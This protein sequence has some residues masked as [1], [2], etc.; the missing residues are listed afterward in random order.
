VPYNSGDNADEVMHVGPEWPAIAVV[1]RC[2]G[3]ASPVDKRQAR[4]FSGLLAGEEVAAAGNSTRLP[5]GPGVCASVPQPAPGPDDD[6][7]INRWVNAAGR[8]ACGP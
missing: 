4:H 1:P 8:G 2:P 3:N 7:I 6:D 5:E